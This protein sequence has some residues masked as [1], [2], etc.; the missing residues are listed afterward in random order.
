MGAG[1][2]TG[3]L[4]TRTQPLAGQFQQPEAADS[5]DLDACAVRFHRLFEPALHLAQVARFLHV[6]E[7]YDDQ[8]RQVAQPELAGDFLRRFDIGAERGFL[9]IAFAR[10]AARVHVDRDQGFRRLDHDVAARLELHVGAVNR[11]QLAF[12]LVAVE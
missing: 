12:D 5:T 10:R 8:P 7:I 11:V 4:E 2:G 3:F 9:D 6:D 1:L